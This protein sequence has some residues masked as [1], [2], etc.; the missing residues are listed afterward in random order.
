MSRCYALVAPVLLVVLSNTASAQ[1]R[2]AP[3]KI[4]YLDPSRYIQTRPITPPRIRGPIGLRP[5]PESHLP[6]ELESD[7]PS[8]LQ[9]ETGSVS[10]R[11]VINPNNGKAYREIG[12][13]G[14]K[15]ER[16]YVGQARLYYKSNGKPYYEYRGKRVWANKPWKAPTTTQNIDPYPNSSNPHSNGQSVVYPSMNQGGVSANPPS[17]PMQNQQMHPVGQ[18]VGGIL[19][20]VAEADRN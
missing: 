9:I 12:R 18:I 20:I 14:K 11:Y 16:R 10:A 4:K 8:N 2:I 7:Q 1:I 5:A 6:M 13:P 19:Q 3:E 17:I 15:V